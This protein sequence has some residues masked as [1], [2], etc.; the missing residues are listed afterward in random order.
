MEQQTPSRDM[1]RDDAKS[2][3]VLHLASLVCSVKNEKEKNT[4]THRKA[5]M[6]QC[7]HELLLLQ[8]LPAYR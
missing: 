5:T 2:V 4:D 3:R 1:E 8:L 6:F 7:F